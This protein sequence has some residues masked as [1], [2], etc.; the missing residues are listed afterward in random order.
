M[1]TFKCISADV[2]ALSP[3]ST[4][5]EVKQL[6][7]Y[8]TF[9]HLP[10]V[11]DTQLIGTINE[12]DIQIQENEAE[13]LENLSYL[14]ESFHAEES[15]SWLE[16]LS[17]FATNDA[18]ILPVLNKKKEYT[19]YFELNNILHLFYDTPFLNQNGAIIIVE[20]DHKGYSFSEISQ[21]VESNDCNLLGLFI[22][23][24]KDDK[25]QITLKMGYCNLTS[26]IETF[27]RYG[28]SLLTNFHNDE[29]IENLKNRSEYLQKYINM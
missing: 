14:Y 7:K 4:V 9:T 6:F 8:L 12:K 26:I 20:K 13:T 27:N 16:L 28:Y 15:M 24:V 10:I 17:V 21:I 2:C 23:E 18:N 22:S 3:K 25:I 5:K 29:F 1:N 11:N 19:G